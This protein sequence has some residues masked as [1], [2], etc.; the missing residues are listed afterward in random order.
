MKIAIMGTRG[1]PANYG[2]FETFA[3]EL[4]WRLVERGHEVTV[5]GRK[6]HI[7]HPEKTYRGVRLVVLPTIRHKYFDTVA[8][9]AV[10][11]MHSLK[12]RYDV[13]LVC[14]GANA[15]F[16]WIPRVF[17][18]KVTINVDGIERQRKKWNAIGRA[19]YRL[20]ERLSTIVPNVMISDAGVIRDYYLETYKK[21]SVMI[22][23]GTPVGREP[24]PDA[25]RDLDLDPE[26]YVLYVAR[27]EPEN[28]AHKVIEAFEGLQTDL[29]LAIVGGAPYA[30]EYI[31]QLHSTKDPRIKFL[32]FVYGDGYR[33]LQQ[34]AFAYVQATEVGGTHPA[35]IE[36]MGYGNCV[37]A[38]GTP[39]NREVLGDGGIIY[40]SVPDLRSK[41]QALADDP[42]SRLPY[43]ERAMNRARL[44]SWEAV[45]DQYEDLF[46]DM[47]GKP[48]TSR[49]EAQT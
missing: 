36:A 25:V 29:N 32:G 27:L 49:S 24:M 44:Y 43:R 40:E 20:C 19:Y 16:A 2:G 10:S 14:N 39:E 28:N 9:T 47:A 5:Y 12:E 22:P 26:R 11:A 31:R 48:R 8:H 18:A 4:S 33:A 46:Y 41:L 15:P 45:T 30:T 21:D 38:F 34:S 23:Y 7:T 37:L 17:G 35:L 3:E 1:I 13:I 6:H 42:D